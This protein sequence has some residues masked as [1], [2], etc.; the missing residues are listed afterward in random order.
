MELQLTLLPKHWKVLFWITQVNNAR[1]SNQLRNLQ[2]SS[3]KFL[4][5]LVEIWI[6]ILK[7]MQ[8][9]L[10]KV[11]IGSQMMTKSPFICRRMQNGLAST[12]DMEEQNV[13]SS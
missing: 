12:T 6:R 7:N 1:K 4:R 11:S 13:L 8:P 5:Q 2:K 9:L 3:L 10:I